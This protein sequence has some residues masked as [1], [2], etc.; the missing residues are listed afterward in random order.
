ME[1]QQ[2]S[3]CFLF[4][5]TLKVFSSFIS[6]ASP[7]LDDN[8]ITAKPKKTLVEAVQ[9]LFRTVR[10]RSHTSLVYFS[11]I[12]KLETKTCVTK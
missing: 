10:R 12:Q 7:V 4:L 5:A 8:A 3:V 11:E 2:S 6:L 9:G 1:V